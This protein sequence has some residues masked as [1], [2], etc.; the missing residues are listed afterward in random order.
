M[1]MA[2]IPE[3]KA[4]C[5]SVLDN[6][7]CTNL[8]C[9]WERAL[10]EECLTSQS[11]ELSACFPP[12]IDLLGQKLGLIALGL[13]LLGPECSMLSNLFAEALKYSD[14]N[15]GVPHAYFNSVK[16]KWLLRH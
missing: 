2:V 15:M 14:D 6:D 9:G 16:E 10:I 8:H 12:S 4:M 3:G 1:W 5:R 7:C 13:P 11:H